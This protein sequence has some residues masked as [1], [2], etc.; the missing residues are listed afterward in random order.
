MD[1]I[2]GMG[3]SEASPR[4]AEDL[5]RLRDVTKRLTGQVFYG[6]MLKTMQNSKLKGKFGHGGRGED[7]FAAQLHTVLTERMGQA[8]PKGLAETL[9]RR[10]ERQQTALSRSS[11]KLG[12]PS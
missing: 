9:Y 4:V 6:E 10:L 2:H 3:R 5:N 1:A 7:I 11:S 12:V 8:T